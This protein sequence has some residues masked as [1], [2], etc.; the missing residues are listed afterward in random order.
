MPG[1]RCVFHHSN[2]SAS[3]IAMLDEP[4]Y[5]GL[6]EPSNPANVLDDALAVLLGVNVDER[7]H[8]LT[9]CWGGVLQG[10]T[11]C[12][13]PGFQP[14]T[15]HFKNKL[16]DVC[17]THGMLIPADRVHALPPER[18]GEFSNASSFG[19]WSSTSDGMEFRLINQTAKCSKPSLVILRTAVPNAAEHAWA[20]MPPA[21]LPSSAAPLVK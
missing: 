6:D 2:S 17:K 13:E 9:C 18:H 19:L 21:W 7:A 15:G 16:C 1:P 8:E 11:T 5:A 20:P 10:D 14:R 4:S 3:I 12:C